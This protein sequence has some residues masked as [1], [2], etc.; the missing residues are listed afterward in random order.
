MTILNAYI[1]SG[2]LTPSDTVALFVGY[3]TCD[4]QFVVHSS[5][6]WASLHSVCGQATY[7]CVPLTSSIIWYRPRAVMLSGW[8]GNCGPDGK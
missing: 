8:E 2:I 5:P 6:G 3:R 4:S 7:T 1:L